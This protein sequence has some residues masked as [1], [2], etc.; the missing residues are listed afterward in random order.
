MPCPYAS[1][2]ST[3]EGFVRHDRRIHVEPL[4]QRAPLRDEDGRDDEGEGLLTREGDGERDVRLAEA[5][6]VG[7]QGSAVAREDP[8]QSLGG[9]NLMRREPRRPPRRLRRQRRA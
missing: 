2:P 4:E 8:A 6:G 5:H 9:G 7:E 1:V 3:T